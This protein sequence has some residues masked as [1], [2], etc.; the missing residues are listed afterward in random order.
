MK[1]AIVIIIGLL[2]L[3]QGCTQKFVAHKIEGENEN[4]TS[5]LDYEYT[6]TE[7]TKSA[8]LG[9][10]NQS[11]LLYRKCIALDSTKVVPYYQIANILYKSNQIKDAL[12][13]AEKGFHFDQS[14]RW[15]NSL[16]V[17]LYQVDKKPDK[18]LDVVAVLV[19][20]YPDNPEFLFKKASLLNETGKYKQAIDILN[21]IESN[22]GISEQISLAKHNIYSTNNQNLKAEN[23]LLRLIEFAPDE[24]RYYAILAEFYSNI[25]EN[26]KATAIYNDL[27]T[28]PGEDVFVTLSAAEHYRSNKE[29]E[30]AIELYKNAVFNNNLEEGEKVRT[31]ITMITDADFF[32]RTYLE[33]GQIINALIDESPANIRLLT[34]RA[35][36]YIRIRDFNSAKNDLIQV[37][38][39]NQ[40]NYVIWEQLLFI[41]NSLGDYESLKTYSDKA[42]SNFPEQPAFFMFNGLANMQAGDNITAEKKFTQG[43]KYVGD[44]KDLRIQFLS[45]LGD[46]Q[47][48]LG[49]DKKSDG[50]FEQV[51][52]LD[53]NNI[54]VLNNYSYYLSLREENLNR[55]ESMSRKTLDIDPGNPTY[56]DTYAWILFKM[57]KI[58]QAHKYIVD[59]IKAGGGSN[60][61]ILEHYGDILVE[62]KNL[63]EAVRI[64]KQALEYGGDNQILTQKINNLVND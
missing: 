58:D 1:N 23:E 44:E 21:R 62:L 36:Y 56:L 9:D 38:N 27:L 35:D 41:L 4:Q 37:V 6:L 22:L 61:E 19:D 5:Q 30:K 39:K 10:L 17:D 57:G 20:Q 28:N 8:L 47:R 52:D 50:Y 64:Y 26:A 24:S 11:I 31:I 33:T 25:N 18:A 15:L 54:I 32:Q 48:S 3:F 49:N 34:L 55:A 60:P 7:A 45:M 12:T 59:A 13:Y 63:P 42:L 53:P 51:L 29:Y 43:L 46:V 16:L 2:F 14:N 40:N